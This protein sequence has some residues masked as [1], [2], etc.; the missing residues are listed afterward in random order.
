M[1][2]EPR[3]NPVVID[4]YLADVRTD[5]EAFD[6]LFAIKNRMAVYH[7]Q[8]AAEKLVKAVRLGRGLLPTKEHALAILIEGP[9]SARSEPRPLPENDPWRPLLAPLYWLTSY[10]T[11]FRYPTEGDRRSPGPD[12]RTLTETRRTL[13]ELL[14]RARDELL[15]VPQ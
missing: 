9:D 3:P 15:T 5:P 13:E 10:A 4:A 12:H 11:A 14:L 7:L 2:A 8:Q 6:A 1:A